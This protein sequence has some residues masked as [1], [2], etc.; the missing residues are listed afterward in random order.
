MNTRTPQAVSPIICNLS[1]ELT[2]DNSPAYVPV[3]PLPGTDPLEC[4]K[5]VEDQVSKKGGAVCFGWRFWEFP[6][7]SVWL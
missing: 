5:V 3:Q 1:L 2:G 7:I 6:G 4:F